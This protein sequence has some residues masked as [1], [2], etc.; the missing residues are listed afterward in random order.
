M[1]RTSAG[2]HHTC[3]YDVHMDTH[4]HIE[5]AS[6]QH[7]IKKVFDRKRGA[8]PMLPKEVR[9]SQAKGG[10]PQ[11]RTMMR[12]TTRSTLVHGGIVQAP[13]AADPALA[14]GRPAYPTSPRPWP[15]PP[16]AYTSRPA[17]PHPPSPH[18]PSPPPTSQVPLPTSRPTLFE[19]HAGKG[20]RAAGP[21]EGEARAEAAASCSRSRGR[22]QSRAREIRFCP[23]LR[24]HLEMRTRR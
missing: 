19:E 7:F 2:S 9:L 5:R 14:R 24:Q 23:T 11:S 12:T 13:P 10:N 1:L 18:P 20:C 8:P 3:M 4:V 15:S 16:P 17:S 22:L 6:C 21:A